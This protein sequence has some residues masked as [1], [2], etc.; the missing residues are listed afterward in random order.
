MCC[1]LP[2]LTENELPL[3]AGALADVA[4]D[5]PATLPGQTGEFEEFSAPLE[6][7]LHMATL[8]TWGH[9]K[10]REYE[11]TYASTCYDYALAAFRYG[12]IELLPGTTQRIVSLPDGRAVR[13]KRDSA[14]ENAALAALER[15]GLK[16]VRPQ[17][18]HPSESR[19]ESGQLLGL[20]S[21]AAWSGFFAD[22][23]PA[24]REAGWSI[25]CQADFRHR[26]LAVSGWN[27]GTRGRR[28]WLVLALA[29][30]RGRRPAGSSWRPCCTSCSTASR[31]GSSRKSSN[32][33]PTTRA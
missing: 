4:P 21:E 9:A 26:V 32:E 20:A 11:H 17:W 12:G 14:A 10:H 31:A 25:E 7:V 5:L 22:Q 3:V 23:V 33:S 28:Q 13:L 29:R 27:A 18:L 24:L 30:H 6:A 16:P 1:K 2:P 15:A 8:T 19:R